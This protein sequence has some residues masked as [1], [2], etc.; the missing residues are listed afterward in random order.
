MESKEYQHQ[1]RSFN[2]KI[3]QL[4][5][6]N[7]VCSGQALLSILFIYISPQT[8]HIFQNYFW[9]I[10]FNK[11]SEQSHYWTTQVTKLGHMKKI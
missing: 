3:C 7:S 4:R 10:S 11:E 6:T 5:T 2:H 9:S 1:A 8:Q